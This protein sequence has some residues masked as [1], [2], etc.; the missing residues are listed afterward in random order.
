MKKTERTALTAALFAAALNFIPTGTNDMTSSASG[1]D[2]APVGVD[3]YVPEADEPIGMYGPP[4]MFEQTTAPTT[5]PV[6]T[7]VYPVYGSAPA[8]TTVTPASS[9]QTTR[10]PMLT[11]VYTVYGT[12]PAWTTVTP[13]SS[14]QTTRPPMLTDVY[15][16]YGTMPAWTT[17]PVTT[18]YAPETDDPICVYGPPPVLEKDLGDLDYD[19]RVT[20]FDMVLFRQNFIDGY[21][22]TIDYARYDVNQDGRI[23]VADLVMLQRYLLGQI[24]SLGYSEPQPQPEYGAPWAY[25][26]MSPKL[27]GEGSSTTAT[28]ADIP[29]NSD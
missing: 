19:G 13:A 5:E 23:G 1:N 17:V 27:N 26:D 4:W 3:E 24:D 12:M 20:V 8:W 2:A 11:E 14:A 21:Y 29:S 9:A 18:S 7:E 22:D 6:R 10:P 25:N 16:V 15:T 28:A